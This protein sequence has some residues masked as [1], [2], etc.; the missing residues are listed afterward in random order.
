MTGDLHQI[1]ELRAIYN[2]Q[3]AVKM[4][5]EHQLKAMSTRG[6][7][8][9]IKEVDFMLRIIEIKCDLISIDETINQLYRL[10]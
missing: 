3:L 7:R 10:K 1:K 2:S 4:E 5:L 6:Y 8:N 9:A